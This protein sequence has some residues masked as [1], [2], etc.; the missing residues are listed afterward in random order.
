MITGDIEG[1]PDAM[2]SYGSYTPEPVPE[3]MVALAGAP[4]LMVGIPTGVMLDLVGHAATAGFLARMVQGIEQSVANAATVQLA[5]TKYDTAD[6]ASA[7]TINAPS[8]ADITE[9]LGV[10]TKTVN[11]GGKVIDLAQKASALGQSGDSTDATA[12]TPAASA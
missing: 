2:A 3:S 6:Q 5:S 12:D 10:L 1:N 4:P 8:A 11:L 7:I 9:I